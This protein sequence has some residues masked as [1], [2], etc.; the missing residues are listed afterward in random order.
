MNFGAAVLTFREG[1]EAALIAAIMLGYL[2]KVGRLDMQWSVWAGAISAGAL[3]VGFTLVLQ[4]I[5]AQF[6]YPAK[7]VYEGV[8]SLLA[9]VMLTSMI[10]WMARQARYIKGSLEHSMK[11]RLAQGAVWGLLALAFMTVAREGVETALF[12]SA[13][14]F[15]SSGMDTLV[16]GIMGLLVSGVVAWAVYVAGVRLQLRT[17]FK[18]TSILLVIFGAAI[19]RYAIHEF[20][21]VNWLPPLVEPVWNTGEW[22]PTSSVLGSVLQALIGY[23]SRPSLMQLIG[24]FGYLMAFGW[25]VVRPVAAR[26]TGQPQTVAAPAAQSSEPVAVLSGTSLNQPQVTHTPSES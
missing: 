17:F 24:Y 4:L 8:T 19:L 5:G 6:D 12:L 11:D 13:S 10:L 16:G 23:T 18:V 25:L 3:A 9:V 21:E 2:R 22:V 14:A 1:L 26:P 20:E 7:G 15:Q